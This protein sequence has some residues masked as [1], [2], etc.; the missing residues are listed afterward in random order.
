VHKE[1][2]A[3]IVRHVA[4]SDMGSSEAVIRARRP[5]SGI[6]RQILHE[7]GLVEA[8]WLLFLSGENFPVSAILDPLFLVPAKNFTMQSFMIAI[9]SALRLAQRGT[10]AS[11]LY[12]RSRDR[13]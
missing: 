9:P 12:E 6:R 5:R 11:L 2:R 7:I 8:P 13:V 3:S 4:A 1:Y 10:S